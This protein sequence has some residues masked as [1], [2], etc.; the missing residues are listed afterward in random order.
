MA[1]T[2]PVLIPMAFMYGFVIY[3]VLS[4]FKM[5]PEI[6]NNTANRAATMFKL[7]TTIYFS[8][9]IIIFYSASVNPDCFNTVDINSLLQN[10][11]FDIATKFFAD[12]LKTANE[13]MAQHPEFKDNVEEVLLLNKSGILHALPQVPLK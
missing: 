11:G 5:L 12:Y 7:S 13:I 3:G 8:K 9:L 2:L 6:D 4:T 10:D 1:E